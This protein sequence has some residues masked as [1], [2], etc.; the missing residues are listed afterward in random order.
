MKRNLAV[1]SK[2]PAA[3][4]AAHTDQPTYTRAGFKAQL[5]KV[6]DQVDVFGDEKK[7]E[8]AALVH[9]KEVRYP[10]DGS[11]AFCVQSVIECLLSQR[12]ESILEPFCVHILGG[13]AGKLS[14]MLAE[15]VKTLGPGAREVII[16]QSDLIPGQ[17]ADVFVVSTP[18]DGHLTASK[19]DCRKTRCG[20]RTEPVLRPR[21]YVRNA[22]LRCVAAP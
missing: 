15:A 14:Q 2:C 11:Y 20:P 17:H 8:S 1:S 21:A 9:H 5:K 12:G 3:A 10:N 22:S 7:A 13:A 6:R 16:T 18:M 19:S 4:A